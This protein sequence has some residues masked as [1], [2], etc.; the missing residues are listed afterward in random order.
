VPEFEVLPEA[1]ADAGAHARGLAADVHD[2]LRNVGG[3]SRT[4][5]ELMV[6]A[7]L[8]DMLAE[9]HLGL[10]ALASFLRQHGGALTQAAGVYRGT[11][12]DAADAATG[13][14]GTIGT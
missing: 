4:L 12:H 2:L 11:D 7:A 13:A 8:K 5:A 1:L 14:T 9:F 6:D 3:G 10:G